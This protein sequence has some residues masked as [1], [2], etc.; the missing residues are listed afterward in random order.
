[1]TPKPP[2]GFAH[3][4]ETPL[5]YVTMT[6]DGAALT[7]L[8]FEDRDDAYP[9]A[10]CE[11]RG[12]P[13]FDQADRWL[14]IYFAGRDPGF[15]PPLAVSGTEFRLAVWRFAADIPYGRITTYGEIA[16]ALARVR[17]VPLVS[18]QAVGGALA[19][20]PVALIVPCHR[21]IGARG[22]A[23]GYAFGIDRKLKLLALERGVP[24]AF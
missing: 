3:R 7:G 19:H 1:M 16:A 11:E 6:S 5:G 24:I 15:A 10:G 9:P 20:N 18:A 2:C 4:R 14:D 8:R 23:T 12:L 21:V 17:G 13:V 22:A